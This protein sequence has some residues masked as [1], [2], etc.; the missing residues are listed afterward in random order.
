MPELT[1]NEKCKIE[2]NRGADKFVGIKCDN[3]I[4]CV[5][6]PLGFHVSQDI[7]ELRKD[8][9]LLLSVLGSSTSHMDSEFRM[10]AKKYEQVKFPV[11]AYLAIIYD[12]YARGYYKER[13]V[14]YV[15]ARRG[16]INWSRTLKTQRPYLQDENAFYLDF[17]TKRNAVNVDEI[18]TKIHEYCVYESFDKMGWLFTDHMPTR[19]RIRFNHKFFKSVIRDKMAHTFNDKNRR[20]FQNM[21]AVLENLGDDDSPKKFYYGTYRFQYVWESLVDKVYGIKNKKEYF[22]ETKWMIEGKADSNARLRPD[23]IMIWNHNI[24]VLDAKYYSYCLSGSTNDLPGT[25]SISKQITY[26]EYIDQKRQSEGKDFS[27][28]NAFIMPFDASQKDW[29]SDEGIVRIGEAVSDWKEND[30][31]YEKVQGILVDAKQ[32][33]KICV[34][35][36]ENEIKKLSECI[37]RACNH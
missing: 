11:H 9:I 29:C 26:G 22:P 31:T 27:I 21:L 17:V 36:D 32:L 6:F 7:R 1:I 34:R 37:E 5:S 8:I 10:A 33:M 4:I 13:E 19:P 20:L 35:Q 25:T 18:I 14:Q 28:Y 16:K 23:T 30:K 12:F 2:T 24:Y 3:G 15:T